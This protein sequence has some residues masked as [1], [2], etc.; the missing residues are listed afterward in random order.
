MQGRA[1]DLHRLPIL[2]QTLQPNLRLRFSK[3]LLRRSCV[4]DESL[5]RSSVTLYGYDTH[6]AG[7]PMDVSAAERHDCRRNSWLYQRRS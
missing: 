2:V 1:A 7:N 4:K 6:L 3:L 5:R